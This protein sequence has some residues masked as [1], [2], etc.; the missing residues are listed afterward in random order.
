MF[1][2]SDIFA[3]PDDTIEVWCLL[4]VEY[5][6]GGDCVGWNIGFGNINQLVRKESRSLSAVDGEGS[7]LKELMEE[8][9]H[10]HRNKEVR[11]TLITPSAST[12]PRLRTRLLAHGF[13]TSFRGLNHLC[14]ETLIEEYFHQ[15]ESSANTHFDADMWITDNLGVLDGDQPVK[16]LWH[17]VK[18]IG[19]LVPRQAMIGTRL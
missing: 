4:M 16:E 14:F 13:D 17:R 9:L 18:Q 19:P 8:Y 7:L 2:K 3:A 1:H 15:P 12:L 6:D 11:T 5:S 10:P